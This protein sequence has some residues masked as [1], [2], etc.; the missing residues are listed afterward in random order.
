MGV[1]GFCQPP[2]VAGSAAPGAPHSEI[3]NQR[4]ASPSAREPSQVPSVA[5]GAGLGWRGKERVMG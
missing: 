4:S 2:E 1:E 3:C 5:Y